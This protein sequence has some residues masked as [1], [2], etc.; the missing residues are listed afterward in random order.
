MVPTT[1][2]YFLSQ[3]LNNEDR[4]LFDTLLNRHLQKKKNVLNTNIKYNRYNV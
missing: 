3:K 2:N 1:K 4:I